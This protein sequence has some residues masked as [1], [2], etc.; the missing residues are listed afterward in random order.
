VQISILLV[1]KYSSSFVKKA[2][3]QR[4]GDINHEILDSADGLYCDE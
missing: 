4:Q 3:A 2:D 1:E